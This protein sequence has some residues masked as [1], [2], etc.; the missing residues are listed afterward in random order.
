VTFV[1]AGVALIALA[2]VVLAVAYLRR[3]WTRRLLVF[4]GW[5]LIFA[6][7]WLLGRG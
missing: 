1:L 3:S 7:A 5:A 6:G 4:I 2:V